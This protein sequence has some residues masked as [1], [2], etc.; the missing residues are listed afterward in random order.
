FFICTQS[1][2]Q[3]YA[4]QR[5]PDPKASQRFVSDDQIMRT[6]CFFDINSCWDCFSSASV[7]CHG[8]LKPRYR[9]P[10]TS[11]SRSSNHAILPFY[12]PSNR[13]PHDRDF[14]LTLSLRY[15]MASKP[16]SSGIPYC[17][18]LYWPALTMNGFRCLKFEISLTSHGWTSPVVAKYL[19]QP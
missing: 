19:T 16:Q 2:G 14:G 15:R 8:S 10:M 6:T 3:A 9:P 7:C 4:I 18:P 1:F 17:L 12:R 11:I 5:S 13:S